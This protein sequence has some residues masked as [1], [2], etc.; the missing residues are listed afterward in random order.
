MLAFGS[1]L[2]LDVCFR[3]RHVARRT[4][5]LAC[6]GFAVRNAFR[7]CRTALKAVSGGAS[8]QRSLTAA[9]WT[10]F[11]PRGWSSRPVWAAR[12]S[13]TRP[14]GSSWPTGCSCRCRKS[15]RTDSDVSLGQL[16]SAAPLRL[17]AAATPWSRSR[18][19][20]RLVHWR[21]FFRR[22]VEFRRRRGC[23]EDGPWLRAQAFAQQLF[24]AAL[25]VRGRAM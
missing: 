2:P 7:H 23:E 17:A 18:S 12:L 11:V 1:Q 24:A 5:R 22:I 25:V 6:T 20:D 16:R 9:R 10:H 8:R 13:G 19:R 15:I 3:D 21:P 14:R 4:R